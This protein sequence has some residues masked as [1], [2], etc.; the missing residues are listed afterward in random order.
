MSEFLSW[1]NLCK[2]IFFL[3]LLCFGS[4]QKCFEVICINSSLSLA[5]EVPYMIKRVLIC[6]V[7]TQTYKYYSRARQNQLL[8]QMFSVLISGGGGLEWKV[9]YLETKKRCSFT[10]VEIVSCE[11]M[12]QNPKFSAALCQSSALIR[13]RTILDIL[14]QY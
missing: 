5:K 7:C 12:K 8:A 11:K 14:L 10:L 3:H 1:F 4:L 9:V 6:F 2:P 13:N